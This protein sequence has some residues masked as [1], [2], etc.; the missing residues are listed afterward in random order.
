MPRARWYISV[1]QE[2]LALKGAICSLVPSAR[3]RSHA[4]YCTNRQKV[5]ANDNLAH[6]NATPSHQQVPCSTVLNPHVDC[7][8]NA[9]WVGRCAAQAYVR[10]APT[11]QLQCKM[12][13]SAS[14]GR[15]SA[16]ART[17]LDI[18]SMPGPQ[19]DNKN[20]CCEAARSYAKD[21]RRCPAVP[22]RTQ[23]QRFLKGH[24]SLLLC[25]APSAHSLAI[26]LKECCQS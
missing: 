17:V 6:H 14:R 15:P 22:P 13:I 20:A 8:I 18:L 21:L 26:R 5:D 23:N 10:V 2:I 19:N 16:C 25:L 7:L 12:I 3:Q 1:E 9:E 24:E 4:A 11:S